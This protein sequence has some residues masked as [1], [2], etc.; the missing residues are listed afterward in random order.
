MARFGKWAG[1]L[2]DK[3]TLALVALAQKKVSHEI[4]NSNL[5]AHSLFKKKKKKKTPLRKERNL[6]WPR[7]P[8]LES[9]PISH[10]SHLCLTPKPHTFLNRDATPVATDTSKTTIPLSLHSISSAA[11]PHSIS[12]FFF[13]QH[14]KKL[15]FFKEK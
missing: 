6:Y 15:Y 3:A 7:R 10:S 9:I 13:L 12:F 5:P 14:K 2:Y 11:H 4:S 8:I 1:V